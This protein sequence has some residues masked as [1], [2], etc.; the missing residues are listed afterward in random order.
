MPPPLNE[1]KTDPDLCAVLD[2]LADKLKSDLNCISI[3]AIKMFYPDTQTADIALVY[4][5][6]DLNSGLLKDHQLLVK[7]PVV[8]LNGGGGS[9]TF[10]I[11][12]G[13]SCI[14]FFCDREIDTWFTNGGI[15]APQ[16][17]RAHDLNDGIALVGIR[18][19]L[20]PLPTYSTSVMRLSFGGSTI[21]FYGTGALRINSSDISVS[22]PVPTVFNPGLILM[23]SGSIANIPAGFVLCDGNNNTPDLTD[24]FIVGAKQDVG[25]IAKTNITGALTKSGGDKNHYHYVG[26]G[27][28]Y[29]AGGGG[30][31]Y[32]AYP[33]TYSTGY[34][35]DIVVPYYA[36]AFIMK[37]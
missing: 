16:S 4:K 15:N 36:L 35:N 37:T 24:K 13:D 3:G 31:T 29:S 11:V 25:G 23:W 27:G 2:Q 28:F 8:V 18:N 17:V 9:L 30:S 34:P 20:N 22:T 14:V 33:G 19:S 21:D 5:R 12:A 6:I 32:F 1:R 26:I 7:C 10:P